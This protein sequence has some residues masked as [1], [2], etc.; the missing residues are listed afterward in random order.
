MNAAVA[1]TDGPATLAR[2]HLF[3][4]KALDGVAVDEATISEGGALAGDRRF[5]LVEIDGRYVN[6]KR[7]PEVHG[8]RA[9]PAADGR[10][11]RLAPAGEAEE[12]FDLETDG[13]RLAAWAGARLGR[14]VRLVRDDRAGFPDDPVASG[15]TVL[16]TASL[17]AVS[18][19]F[20]GLTIQD[21]RRRFRANLEIE[22]VPAFWEDRLFG[23]PGTTVRFR[24]GELLFE[25]TNPCQRCV[26][27][28]RD[29][30]DGMAW[31]RFQKT[32]ADRRRQ[33]L[34]EGVARAAFDHFYRFAVNTRIVPGQAGRRLRVGD[35]WS[36]RGET[37]P[38]ALKPPP[39]F[40]KFW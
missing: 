10:T 34:P 38:P 22:G 2:I 33:H 35:R 28:A 40:E 9:W 21:V 32:F 6:G 1:R 29:P 20:P 25:G 19:W 17:A 15:P 7:C 30:D 18:A 11:V 14:E 36:F 8:W 4:I 31:P 16:S 12:T 37:A 3:P 39:P 23:D 5:A 26:V 27:P 24:I 13:A